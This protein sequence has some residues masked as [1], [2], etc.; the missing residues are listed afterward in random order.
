MNNKSGHK[1]K[2]SIV[3]VLLVFS[4]FNIV[5]AD[6]KPSNNVNTC[7]SS[8][9][10]GADALNN[11][12][13]AY[14]PSDEESEVTNIINNIA[15]DTKREMIYDFWVSPAFGISGEAMNNTK[16]KDEINSKLVET[17]T[18]LA[19]VPNSQLEAEFDRI[20]EANYKYFKSIP[21][22]EVERI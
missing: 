17:Y 2:I 5:F 3:F 16:V 14:I 22:L 4:G 6:D 7:S 10:K 12:V 15:D 21:G 19:S 8:Y 1:F 13:D 9:E 18:Y 20:N 11:Q